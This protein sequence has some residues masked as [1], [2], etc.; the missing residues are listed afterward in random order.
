MI[1]AMHIGI[2][3]WCALYAIGGWLLVSCVAAIGI[4]M[5][6]YALWWMHRYPEVKRR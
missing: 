3:T 5:M 2:V 6:V 1:V 4:M